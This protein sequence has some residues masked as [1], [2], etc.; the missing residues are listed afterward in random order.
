MIKAIIFDT[1]GVLVNTPYAMDV[2]TYTEE[3]KADDNVLAFVKELKHRGLK[4]AVLSNTVPEHVKILESL[5]VF[6]GFDEKV[7]SCKVGLEKPN[8]EIYI[9]QIEPN[10]AIYHKELFLQC[11]R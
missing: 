11:C 7:F 4:I 6:D 8:P 9:L 5:N 10:L 3:I 2:V 1:G